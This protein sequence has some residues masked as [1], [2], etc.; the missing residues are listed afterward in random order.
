M[1][2]HQPAQ[3]LTCLSCAHLT[4][5][6]CA[7]GAPAINTAS[8]GQQCPSMEYEPGTGPKEFGSYGE[9]RQARPTPGVKGGAA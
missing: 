6:T 1:N 4:G 3:P 2:R 5:T 8:Y 9:Y 7:I